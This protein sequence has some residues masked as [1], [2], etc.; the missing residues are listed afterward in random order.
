MNKHIIDA[1]I[2]ALKLVRNVRFLKTERGYQ[3]EF[4]CELKTALYERSILKDDLILEMEYQ[5]AQS[6]HHIG[7]RPDIILHVPAEVSGEPVHENNIAVWALKRHSN[8]HDA[9]DDYNKLDEM[10]RD[11]DYDA[12]FFINLDCNFHHL[13]RYNGNYK[14][15]LFAFSVKLSGNTL[16]IKQASFVLGEIIE[17]VILA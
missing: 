7:Q 14:D 12:G 4:F 17:K 10:L 8:I 3:G 13:E 9:R 16:Q 1:T 2:Q 15:R 11:L 5:K 6:R